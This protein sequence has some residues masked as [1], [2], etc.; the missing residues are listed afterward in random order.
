[1]LL[2]KA[3][4]YHSTHLQVSYFYQIFQ[5]T[6]RPHKQINQLQISWKSL[7][8]DS[9]CLSLATSKS[10]QAAKLSLFP[11]HSLQNLGIIPK[12]KLY[13]DPHIQDIF[14]YQNCHLQH[15]K[16]V[17]T[18]SQVFRGNLKTEIQPPLRFFFLFLHIQKGWAPS[19]SRQLY[20]WC[21]PSFPAAPLHSHSKL[22]SSC[23]VLI[24]S[25]LKQHNFYS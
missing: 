11:H 12:H 16:H 3:M 24:I 8:Q 13:L 25:S 6:F 21:R 23:I 20:L 1:M 4:Q 7:E 19:I 9:R 18:T 15:L 10:V 14:K 2:I 17:S 22:S 5:S